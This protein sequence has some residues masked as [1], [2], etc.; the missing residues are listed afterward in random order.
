VGPLL[1]KNSG[2]QGCSGECWLRSLVSDR[3]NPLSDARVLTGISWIEDL[4]DLINEALNVVGPFRRVRFRLERPDPHPNVFVDRPV[5]EGRSMRS[6]QRGENLLEQRRLTQLSEREEGRALLEAIHTEMLG[7]INQVAG[8][9]IDDH[10]MGSLLKVR[11]KGS[12]PLL[13]PVR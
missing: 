8:R 4:Y 7:E 3:P 1:L 11:A 5:V 6:K 12:C 13:F 2:N 10:E 9:R